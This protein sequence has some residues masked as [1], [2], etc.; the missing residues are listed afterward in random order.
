MITSKEGSII[1][2]TM[3][4][5]VCALLSLTTCYVV[6]FAPPAATSAAV[7]SSAASS[8]QVLMSA[9]TPPPSRR[10]VLIGTGA[11]ASLLLI[12]PSVA[13]AKDVTPQSAANKANESF[14]GVYLDPK[15]PTGYR[16]LMAVKGSSNKATMTLNDGNEDSKTF[17]D[18]PVSVDNDELTFDFGFKGGPKGIKGKLSPDKQSITFEDG[19]T[20]TKNFYKYDGIYKVT[21]VG[22]TANSGH[23]AS[24]SEDAYRVIRKSK[25]DI[26]LEINDTGNP[27][28]TYTVDGAIG[29][30]FSVPTS[31]ITFFY[32]G[33]YA[34]Q[35]SAEVNFM[36]SLRDWQRGGDGNPNKDNPTVE[37]QLSLQEWNTVFP[38]GTITFP[39]KTVWT[40]Q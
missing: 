27:K 4:K 11:A 9:S 21:K 29:T 33:K 25:A 30:L 1:T 37:A 7:G 3:F 5:F 40:R 13:E 2:K 36:D 6:G 39:D 8:T 12:N 38:Y 31:S 34:G 10:D 26:I 19:N 15:H 35:T 17:S 16:T 20:W 23:D 18:I 24:I 22:A 28:D 14:Q 32:G